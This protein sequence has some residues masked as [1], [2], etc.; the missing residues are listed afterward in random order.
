MA[1][2]RRDFLRKGSLIAIAAAVPT[3]VVHGLSNRETVTA[4][5]AGF[6]L[7]K[8][9]FLAQLNTEFRIR[10]TRSQVLVKLVEVTDL[11]HRKGARKD[12]EGFSLVFR[13]STVARLDQGTYEIQHEKL[14]KFSFLLVPVPSR[15]KDVVSYE[16]IVN[17]LYS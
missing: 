17:R 5:S 4:L 14:G 16:A 10:N 12:R 15:R 8:A 1:T 11:K 6:E 3:S 13:D 7:N 2:S 9:A